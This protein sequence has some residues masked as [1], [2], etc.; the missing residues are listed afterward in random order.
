MA[1]EAY[2]GPS[3]RERLKSWQRKAPDTVV[4]EDLHWATIHSPPDLCPRQA[5]G[6]VEAHGS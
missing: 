2:A 4:F 6:A 3:F 5:A 1:A